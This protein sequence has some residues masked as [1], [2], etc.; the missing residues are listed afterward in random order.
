M[1]VFAIIAVDL[2]RDFGF[3]GDYRTTQRYGLDDA[4]WGQG[5]EMMTYNPEVSRDRVL[6]VWIRLCTRRYSDA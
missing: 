3:G 5:A 1:M 4:R 2:F 6:R